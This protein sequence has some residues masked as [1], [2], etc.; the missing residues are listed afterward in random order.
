MITKCLVQNLLIFF[1]LISICHP[2]SLKQM[3][4]N[5]AHETEHNQKV[6][7]IT[8][9]DDPFKMAGVCLPSML[10]Q[11]TCC[12]GSNSSYQNDK[13]IIFLM[14]TSSPAFLFLTFSIL[15]AFFGLFFYSAAGRNNLL[16]LLSKFNHYGQRPRYQLV[17]VISLTIICSAMWQVGAPAQRIT[18]HSCQFL[19]L[20]QCLK[21]HVSTVNF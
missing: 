10:S 9:V 1:Y 17:L 14:P 5:P 19:Y 4:I 2:T 21:A 18:A 20:N 6:V 16:S 7:I 8:N 12:E 11:L 15:H 13:L 3:F